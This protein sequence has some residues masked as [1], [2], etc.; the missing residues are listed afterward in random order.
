[1]PAINNLRICQKDHTPYNKNKWEVE[2]GTCVIEV[3][4]YDG[5][6]EQAAWTEIH[7]TEFYTPEGSKRLM[8]RN[9]FTTL[10]AGDR[11]KLIEA[12]TNHTA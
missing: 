9:I 3:R 8:T 1:M 12:L 10:D 2:D 6:K 11:E 4:D 5:S 7:I